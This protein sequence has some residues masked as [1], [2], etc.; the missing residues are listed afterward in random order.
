MTGGGRDRRFWLARAEAELRELG[1][2]PRY[3]A[4]SG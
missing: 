1:H 4:G 2:S 3:A